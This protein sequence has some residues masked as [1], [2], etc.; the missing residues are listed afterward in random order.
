MCSTRAFLGGR[1]M[2]TQALRLSLVT[3]AVILWLSGPLFAQALPSPTQDPIAGSRVFGSKGCGKCHAIHGVGP[4]IG[5]DLGKLSEP[6]SFY[7]LAAVLWNHLPQMSKR[8]H[9]LGISQPYLSAREAGDLIAFL[10][11]LNYFDRPGDLKVGRKLFLQKR[12]VTCHQVHGTGGVVGPNLDALARY[13]SPILIATAMWNHGP[14]MAEA[15]QKMGLKRPSFTGTE[16]RHLIAYLKSTVPDPTAE[17]LYVLLGQAGAGRELFT[18]RR[19]SVCHG[20]EG[21]GGSV[22][23]DLA[24]RGIKLN[25]FEFAAA[26]WNKEAAMVQAMKQRNIP[27]PRLEA[28]EMADIISYLYSVQYF[29]RLGDPKRGGELAVAKG[30]LGCHSAAGKGGKVGP[31]FEGMK[32][33][34]D[35]VTIVAAMWNHAGVMEEKMREKAVAWPMLKGQEMADLTVYLQAL[36]RGR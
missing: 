22:G 16:L 1:V 9:K 21:K 35:P 10:F 5:P 11:T 24:G 31:E 29:A 20:A 27:L 18:T 33:L 4:K 8:M 34:E 19:C 25:L 7:D 2:K 26:M 17:P 13:S 14:E 28:E 12:C 3:V 23:A 30:C 6:R 32:G 36:A 15:M